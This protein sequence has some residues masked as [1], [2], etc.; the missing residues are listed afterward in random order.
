LIGQIG[1][2]KSTAKFLEGVGNNPDIKDMVFVTTG[3]PKPAALAALHWPDM[4]IPT[5]LLTKLIPDQLDE[6]LAAF[7]KDG[8]LDRWVSG[9]HNLSLFFFF[10]LLIRVSQLLETLYKPIKN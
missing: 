2:G 8:D 5:Y 6:R 4:S 10:R 3:K 7:K 1:T 9:T